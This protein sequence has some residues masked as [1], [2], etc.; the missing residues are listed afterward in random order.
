[1]KTETIMWLFPIVFMIHDFEEIIMMRPWVDRNAPY[2]KERFP[3]IAARALPHLE[4]LSTSSYALAIF[5]M[6]LSV[7]AV[8]LISVEF[9]LYALWAGVLIGYFIHAILHVTQFLAFRRYVP[10]VITSLITAPYCIW[11]LIVINHRHP[12][13]TDPTLVWTAVALVFIGGSLVL[14]LA[15][16]AR[17]E[18]WLAKTS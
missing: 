16:A 7:S 8:T 15:I 2:L 4:A 17:F 13:P 9:D 6:F 14:F 18:R 5:L 12:L 3:R 10:V 11:A 1:M